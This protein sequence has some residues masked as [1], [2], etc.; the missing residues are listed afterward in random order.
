MGGPVF[1]AKRITDEFLELVSVDSESL[2]ERVMADRLTE[3]LKK[4]GFEV[5]E[6]DAGS[7]IGG[8]AGN[9]FA[10]IRGD[11]PGKPI[12][13]AGHMDTVAPGRSKKPVLHPGGKITSD[14]TTV[15]GADDMAA[16]T[17]ILSGIRAVREA[18]VPHRDIEVLFTAA[19][20]PFGLGS[21]AFDYSKVQAGSAYVLDATGP[22]GTVIV[23]APTILSF[24]VR[25][26]GRGAHA[27]FEPE[28]GIN[29]IKIASLAIAGI[30]Q[31]RID[32]DT[33]LNIGLIEGGSVVNAVPAE[34]R[35]FGEIRSYDHGK[36][37][38]A[39]SRVE[40]AF[41]KE[42]GKL[43]ADIEAEYTVKLRAYETQADSDTVVLAKRSI[44]LL[45]IEPVL[46]KTFGGSD[47]NNL[48]AHG[49]EGVVLSC[50]M[51]DPHTVKEYTNVS[52]LT[53]GAKL[54]ANLITGADIQ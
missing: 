16:V 5:T 34:C 23:K 40:S 10:T 11:I 18:G 36:A 1:D 15:L 39:L 29:A 24:S 9:L 3:K 47:N 17:E 26:K 27:G 43:A 50:G 35:V 54:V 41:R 20:E 49:I 13:L 28:K 32:H 42:A 52:D 53:E 25:V 6:D 14:G 8:N 33:T 45:G 12:L 7:K 2:A 21:G 4:I 51:Y 31:G 22:V 46:S 37:L 38:S 19:E 44:S 48:A 30:E